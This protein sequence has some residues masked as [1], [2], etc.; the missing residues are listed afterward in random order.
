M[1]IERRRCLIALAA[2]TAAAA[3]P[4]RAAGSL[5]KLQ[6]PGRLRVAV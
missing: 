5:E 1:R 6:Q 2:L 3:V 4:A